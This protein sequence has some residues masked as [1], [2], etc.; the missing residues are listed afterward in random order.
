MKFKSKQLLPTFKVVCHLSQPT[1]IHLPPTTPNMS[2]PL[3]STSSLLA[4]YAHCAPSKV[5]FVSQLHTQ[6]SQLGFVVLALGSANHISVFCQVGS[7]NKGHMEKG[8]RMGRDFF[9]LSYLL[10]A[11]VSIR[12]HSLTQKGQLV[13]F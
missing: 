6:T 5:A 13:W 12:K 2:I 11:W 7:G 4:Q 10:P 9:F 8:L 1:P 3:Q